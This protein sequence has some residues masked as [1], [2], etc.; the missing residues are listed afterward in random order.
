MGVRVRA[1]DLERGKEGL[2]SW[3]LPTSLALFAISFLLPA[4]DDP[5]AGMCRGYAAFSIALF[6]PLVYSIGGFAALFRG[7]D[8]TGLLV[9]V[10][11]L[12]W[13]ANVAYGLAAYCRHI[14]RKYVVVAL[15]VLAVVLGLSAWLTVTYFWLSFAPERRGPPPFATFREGY[16]LWLGSMALLVYGGWRGTEN[17]R[18]RTTAEEW[19]QSC[20]D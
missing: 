20:D 3:V 6:G 8:P 12:P 4:L 16:W 9:L 11:L 18:R 2:T 10:L 17:R 1:T 19:A 5:R 15:G 14:E 7:S 13:S